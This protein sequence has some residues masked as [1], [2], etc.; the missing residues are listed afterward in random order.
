MVVKPVVKI[1][2]NDFSHLAFLYTWRESGV[3]RKH[4]FE[5]EVHA[6]KLHSSD[7]PYLENSDRAPA[8]PAT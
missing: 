2:A 5:L 3:T 7:Q 8:P 4:G 6:T 1:L